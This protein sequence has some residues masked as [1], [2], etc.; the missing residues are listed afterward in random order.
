MMEAPRSGPRPNPQSDP[1]A[2]KDLSQACPQT[3]LRALVAV[4]RHLGMDWSLPRILQ[5]HGTDAEPKP[6]Q[7]AR[8]ARAEGLDAAVHKLN[9]DRLQ[10]FAKLIPFLARIDKD[11]WVVIARTGVRPP[12][13]AVE[14]DD[15][16]VVMFD[17][18]KP[19]A[20]LFPMPRK[21][22]L[23]RWTGEI[24]LLKRVY[25]FDD[26]DRRFG[27]G[28]FA[29]EFW[30]QRVLLRNVVIAALAMHVLALAVPVFFQIV[31]DRV[32]VYI[33]ISTL[34]VITVGVVV[35]IAFNSILSWLRGYF[36]LNTASRIDIRL[37][38]TSFRHLMGLPISF[39]EASRAGVITKHMQQGSQIREFLTGRLLQTL[40][41]LPALLVFLPLM[42]WYSVKLTLVVLGVTALLA[43]VIAIMI[44]PYRRRL[45]KLYQAEA[46]RQSLL[47]ETVHGMRTVKS[48]NLEPR[49]EETWD[50]A[51]ADAINTYVQ[52]RK[53]S[54]AATTFSQFI[55]QALTITIVVVAPIWCL[56]MRSVS[57]AWSPSTCCRRASSAR[58][59][60]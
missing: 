56:A 30:K 24:V 14:E 13:G 19:Q 50:N 39:F 21:E 54:L 58:C 12:P 37:A 10:K 26:P 7:L 47:V 51:A 60:R 17:P 52:V 2:G 59:C 20:N 27:L 44:G 29:P 9:W 41:D 6:E 36:V 34:V 38:R 43:A 32:L 3:G 22:F 35:A 31:I 1:E 45:K 18:R 40:L 5:N 53:I 55:E 33:N 42:M 49:R 4:A 11:C 57:A 48:L 28:W 25:K 23:K 46:Q 15:F 16:H 8:I